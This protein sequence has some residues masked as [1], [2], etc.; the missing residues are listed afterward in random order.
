MEL[1]QIAGFFNLITNTEA[2]DTVQDIAKVARNLI[3]YIDNIIVTMGSNG[4]LVVRRNSAKDPLLSSKTSDDVQVRH[5]C[6]LDVSGLVNVSGAGDCLA[7]G[8]ISAMLRGYSE[9]KSIAVGLD[10]ARA[11]LRSISA[12]PAVF[13]DIN[14]GKPAYYTTI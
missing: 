3:A 2:F 10:A 8:I 14:W 4:L 13:N 5:Y 12:V 1:K 6:A 7:A 11:A 9:E